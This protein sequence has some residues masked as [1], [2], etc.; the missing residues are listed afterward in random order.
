MIDSGAQLWY[1][2]TT[3]AG[4]AELADAQ[5]LGAVTSVKGFEGRYL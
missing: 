2:R 4:M 3:S 5:D 1:D